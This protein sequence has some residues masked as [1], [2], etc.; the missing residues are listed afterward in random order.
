MEGLRKLER[1]WWFHRDEGGAVII[2]DRFEADRPIAFESALIGLGTWR[3]GGGKGIYLIETK[4]GLKLK[5]RV[6]SPTPVDAENTRIANPGKESVQRLGIRL[7][8]PT[9]SASIRFLINH[10]RSSDPPPGD[11]LPVAR[12][13]ADQMD[14]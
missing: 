14:L 9:S 4:E 7:K 11:P 13:I 10:A 12:E 1:Q 8:Q 3:D 2:E 6:E 5:V